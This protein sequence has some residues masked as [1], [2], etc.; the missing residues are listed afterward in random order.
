M[1][2][3]GHGAQG[4]CCVVLEGKQRVVMDAVGAVCDSIVYDMTMIS[5]S[6][7]QEIL[8]SRDMMCL[9]SVRRTELRRTESVS[10]GTPH[11]VS[12]HDD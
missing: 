12:R 8:R 1:Q 2:S 4:T 11:R 7:D 3:Q 9:T 6:P 5:P 10:Q